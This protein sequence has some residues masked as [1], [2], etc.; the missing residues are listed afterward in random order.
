MDVSISLHATDIE[1]LHFGSGWFCVSFPSVGG[2]SE[3]VRSSQP[4]TMSSSYPYQRP[5]PDSD[6]RPDP[7]RS[8]SAP[9]ANLYRRPH[10]SFSSSSHSLSSARGSAAPQL[11][12]SSQDGV[13]SIL[14]SCGLEPADLSVLAELPE[15]VLTVDS[16]PHILKQIKGKRGGSEPFPPP[17]SSSSFPS[18]SAPRPST[19]FSHRER[20]ERPSQLVQYPLGQ[21]SSS[22]SQSD[23]PSNRWESAST[24]SSVRSPPSSSSS[25]RHKTDYDYRPSHSDY[26][27][28]ALTPTAAPAPQ[29]FPSRFSGLGPTG[30]RAV[31]PPDERR[32]K[33]WEARPSSGLLFGSSSRRSSRFSSSTP[34]MKEA[35][36]FHG[37]AAEV[38]PYSCSL[39]DITV[40]SEKAWTQHTNCTQH[41]DGQ[42]RL[43]QRFPHWDCRLKNISSDD[44]KSERW[45]DERRFAR[46]AKEPER[47]N[48]NQSQAPQA[49]KA[50]QKPASDRGKVVCVK[51]PA[52][53]VDEVYLRKLTEPFGKILK[54]LM[55]PSLAFVELGSVDQAKDLVKFHTNYPPTVN[56]KQIEFSISSTFS[57]LQSSQVVSFIPAPEGKDGHSDLISIV[58]RFGVPLYTLVLPSKVFVEMKSSAEAQKLV[59]YYSSNKLKI[60]D[61]IINVAFSTEYKSLL[62]VSLAKKYE[63]EEPAKDSDL[64][65]WD[66]S[67]AKQ[68]EQ[69]KRQQNVQKTLQNQVQIQRRPRE[70][71]NQVQVHRNSSSSSRQN[72][73]KE[74]S[75]EAEP[76]LREEQQTITADTRHEEPPAAAAAAAA[77]EEEEEDSMSTDESDAGMEVIAEDGKMIKDEDE[78]EEDMEEGAEDQEQ[79]M[80]EEQRVKEEEEETEDP[81]FPVDL[82]N[83]IT[84]D[85]VHS[86]DQ[87]EGDGGEE[88]ELESSRVV[89]FSPVPQRCT[90]AELVKVMRGFGTVVRC[91]FNQQQASVEMSRPSEAQKAAEELNSNHISINGCRL[92]GFVSRE[93]IR[94]ADGR[95]VKG[96]EDE[97]SDQRNGTSERNSEPGEAREEDH[98]KQAVVV[99]QEGGE[100]SQ[101]SPSDKTEET[102]TERKPPGRRNSVKRKGGPQNKRGSPKSQRTHEDEITSSNVSEDENRPEG[103]DLQQQRET[104]K[105]SD[106]NEPEVT[107]DPETA[108]QNAGAAPP[109]EPAG[110][111]TE[112]E[113]PAKAV[114]TE[115][116]RPVVGYYCNL[117]QLIFYDEDE[118]KR[119][120][121]RTPA[122][123][124]KYQEK[125]G[126]DPWTS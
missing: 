30:H 47:K 53:S 7:R 38:Y 78:E 100:T 115:F 99:V 18:S 95:D 23:T 45:E 55:F 93:N 54:I 1:R 83:C 31:P 113:K 119:D 8:G 66:R 34:S 122:H 98:G 102:E 76:P 63:E 62:K 35:Q 37:T 15:D 24:F 11:P 72:Q 118:A 114:G 110:G 105:L 2:F 46:T 124:A 29:V 16:L 125:T 103:Q 9:D 60:N 61:R 77:A 33:A 56:G 57:F 126:K 89:S 80:T 111:A 92:I 117:C 74:N 26:G 27:K 19:G 112:A 70:K 86:D 67:R 41:A 14:N 42:L 91:L 6:L 4:S 108:E 32:S 21:I 104:E 22:T 36:D 13:L 50:V 43:L 94:L 69:I 52:Q 28:T 107:D 101:E 17:A 81:G 10:E 109:F 59:N 120:H 3:V 121:C 71:Q 65:P 79:L 40:L 68:E 44:G 39:C 20:D 5:L 96:D 123:Y 106:S 88:A 90:D 73:S 85:E 116:V 12:Q 82:E 64:K 51:F 84:L 48:P 25:F 97:Q 75:K 87:G 49:D 58:K